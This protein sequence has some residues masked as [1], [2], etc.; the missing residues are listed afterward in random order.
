MRI[1]LLSV[2]LVS[3]T[4]HAFEPG[5]YVSTQNVTPVAFIEISSH[6]QFV[7]NLKAFYF[8]VRKGSKTTRPEWKTF[9]NIMSSKI[10]FPDFFDTKKLRRIGIDLNSKFALM[11]TKEYGN[12]KETSRLFVPAKDPAK[13]FD[14]LRKTKPK[15]KELK[16]G[17]LLK[18]EA[19]F[20]AKG[21]E[22]IVIANTRQQALSSLLPARKNLTQ[23]EDYKII[24]KEIRQHSSQ[25]A[26]IML[27]HKIFDLSSMLTSFLTSL[28]VGLSTR[29]EIYKHIQAIGGELTGGKKG[30]S[31]NLKYLTDG[32]FLKDKV[33][34]GLDFKVTSK[35]RS[36]LRLGNLS[37]DYF[38]RE[39]FAYVSVLLN[40]I[41]SY[42]VFKKNILPQLFSNAKNIEIQN[43]AKEIFKNYFRG[44][45]S[46]VVSDYM[47]RGPTINPLRWNFYLSIGLKDNV[48]TRN[49]QEAMKLV[50][51][52]TK[53]KNIKLIKGRFQNHPF[54]EF[55]INK[56]ASKVAQEDQSLFLLFQPNE[57]TI[58]TRK[59]DAKSLLTKKGSSIIK[60]KE[61]QIKIQEKEM[62]FF[63]L[64]D[65]D[66]IYDR[67]SRSALTKALGAY[68]AYLKN[69]DTALGFISQDKRKIEF[70][71]KI[72]LK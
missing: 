28:R 31:F 5:K 49:F 70:D 42:S 18:H 43:S 14:L 58:F 7:R 21:K 39:K 57:L 34:S 59:R 6:K 54:W 16:K 1:F 30:I 27:F 17:V 52:K 56:S 22:H 25:I 26:R 63:L 46:F 29:M 45:I 51:D 41:L 36:I 68:L 60:L 47:G 12:D 40:P 38:K 71:F 48:N 4:V 53:R 8:S 2:F 61:R 9:T 62:V 24:Q 15:P 3:A 55:K 64:V 67:L 10:G 33:V 11:I 66:Y 32:N 19:V 69:F 23:R 72:L 20:I 50:F 13:L 35:N 44:D 65:M 37:A